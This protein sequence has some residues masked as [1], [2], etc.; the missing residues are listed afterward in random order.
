MIF[1]SNH[2]I[3]LMCFFLDSAATY[4]MQTATINTLCDVLDFSRQHGFC[5]TFIP[6]VTLLRA[7]H[8]EPRC[9]H[10]YDSGLT[11]ILQ[12]AKVGHVNGRTFQTGND[13]FL[14]LTNSYPI[15]CETFASEDQP[16][17]GLYIRFDMTELVR[18]IQVMSE[19]QRIPLPDADVY[20]NQALIS[21]PMNEA[22]HGELQRL[23]TTLHSRMESKALGASY[24]T[25]IYYQ[26]LSLPQG[27]ALK[28]L[29]QSESKLAR[30]SSAIR[31]MEEHMGARVTVDDLASRA[32]LS[33]SAFHR[34]FKEATGESPLQYLKQIRLNKAKY[35][36]V[37][38]DRCVYAAAA[39]VGYESSTQFSREFKRYFGVPPSRVQDLPYNALVGLG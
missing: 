27:S 14:I 24:L 31:Y 19:Q 4:S 20:A 7:S 23:I 34:V 29:A 8:H 30:V 22:L 16:L 25:R 10:K 15:L 17:L 28:S 35:L 9:P 32:G 12:G 1:L 11:F 2:A 18:L 38:Q 21:C 33:L 3:L 5:P 6:E 37:Y 13:R 26:V 39:A 36:M